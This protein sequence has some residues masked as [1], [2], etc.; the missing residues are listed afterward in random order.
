MVP[1]LVGHHADL[2]QFPGDLI[3][4]LQADCDQGL[5][6]AHSTLGGGRATH[7]LGVLDVVVVLDLEVL[8][9]GHPYHHRE[10]GLELAWF[11]L[12]TPLVAL[13]AA[14]TIRLPLHDLAVED[15]EGGV[16]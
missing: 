13:P 9:A 15:P 6:C 5:G 4:V 12:L 10:Q 14:G 2:Q 7:E 3:G 1:P 8:A 11:L 16:A